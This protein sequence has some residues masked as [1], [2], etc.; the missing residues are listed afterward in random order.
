M[1]IEV[2]LENVVPFRI[3]WARFPVASAV[4]QIIAMAEIVEGYLI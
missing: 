2:V 3:A 4:K 1:S